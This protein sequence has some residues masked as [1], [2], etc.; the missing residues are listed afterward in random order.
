[1]P[2]VWKRNCIIRTISARFT[3]VKDWGTRFGTGSTPSAAATAYPDKEALLPALTGGRD[4]LSAALGAMGET[5]LAEPLPDVRF[6][7]S[8]PTIGHAVIHILSGHTAL[9]L[10]QLVVWRRVLRLAVVT[11]PLNE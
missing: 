4:R 5:G 2:C 1:M 6:R 10:G 3:R 7:D 11:E 8:L 9:H